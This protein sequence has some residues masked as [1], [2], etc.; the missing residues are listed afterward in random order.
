VYDWPDIFL[1]VLSGI[2][3]IAMIT[4]IYRGVRRPR[5]VQR[6]VLQRGLAT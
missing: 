2:G 4:V 5:S 6:A 1:L 3:A